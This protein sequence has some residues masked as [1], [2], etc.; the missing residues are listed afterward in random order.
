M[1]RRAQKKVLAAIIAEVVKG[2]DLG[3]IPAHY[4]T[5]KP[6]VKK[7]VARKHAKRNTRKKGKK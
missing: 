7:P 6:A 4:T 3:P 1:S 2:E 5:A